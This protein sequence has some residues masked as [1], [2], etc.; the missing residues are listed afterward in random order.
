MNFSRFFVDRP[1][2]ASV[3]S[4][5][6]F[7]VGLISIPS[8]PVSEYPEVVPPSVQVSA[9]YPGANPKTISETVATP[10]EEAING[11]ENMIYMKSV[12]GSDGTLTLN[13]TFKLGTDP[14]Q[15]QVQVQNRVSQAL[16]RLP[17]D[18][19]RQG[20]TTQKQSPNL[21]MAV[22][23]ISP[24]DSLDATYI[25]NYAV[26]HIRDELS[27]IPGVGL[28][29]VF[30]SG[31]YA[32]RL[33]VDPQ[34]AA[35]LGVTAADI[36]SSVREQ[37]VQ[38]SAGQIGASPMPN[39]SDFLISIN[40]KGR[41]QS[42]EEFGNV[43]L[44]TG[45]D[46][47]ITRLR[48][49]AR[50]ELASSQ[51]SLRALLN[52]RQ[53]VAI[54]I[55]QSPGS[56]SLEVSA[57]VREKMAELGEQFP[58]GLEW[59]VAYDPTVFVSTSIS[60]VIKTLLEAVLLVVLVVILFLQ[61]W[62]ASLIPL[63][64][65]PVS[66]VGTFAVLLM[67]GFSINTLTLFAMVLA[68]GIVVDDAIVVVENVE[69]NI[70]EGL[71]PLAAAH[72]AMREVSGPI[73]A[74][75]LVLCAVFV[76]MA[77]LDGIT[78]QFY[79]QFATTIAIATIIS[80]I[81]S[82]TLSP[83]LAATLLKP[84]GA[85]PDIPARIIE[86]LFGWLFRPFNRFFQ[87][88][89]ERY[90]RVVGHSLKRRGIVFGAYL[91]LLGGTFALFQ[92]VPGGFIP[93]QDKTYL[94]GSIR[95]PEGAS[96]DRT[97]E[98]ARRVS[99]LAL[100]TEGVANAA[101]FVGF[102]ALQSTN[103]PNV[104][105]VFILFDDF[106][107]RERSAQEIA[108]ELNGK[109]S[110]IKEG[111]AMTFMP[112]PIFGLGAGSGYSLYVQDRRGA[113][114]GELQNATNMLAGA[115]S[116]ASGLSYPFSSYQANVPQMDAEVDRLQ[117]K[118]Q[119]VRMD[120]LFGTLQLYFGSMYINDFNLFGRTYQVVAQA[121]APFRDEVQDLDNL[122]TRNM[123]GEMVP[124]STMVT[125]RQSYGPDPVIRYNGYPAADLM[126]QSD[127]SMLSS[128]EALAA[129]E[130]V[131]SQALPPGM[132]IQ[133]TDLSFQQVNQ[134]NA[135]MVVFPL[136]VL[137]VFLVLAA[138]YESWVMPLA[139]ILIVPMCL[140]A[141]LFGVWATG[142]D[143]NVFVQV[144]LVVLM[145]L[146]CKNAILIVEF[147]RELEMDGKG[148]VEAALEACRLRLRPIIMTSV[149]FIAGVVPLVLASGA[150][151]EVRN[152][153]GITVFT[154]M[155]GVTLFGL[156]L[157]PVFYVALR[158]IAGGKIST[159]K[160]VSAQQVQDTPLPLEQPANG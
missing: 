149:A 78:G 142:G 21:M 153:M 90:Q 43:V 99:E 53:A 103:T 3:L 152:A 151:A 22:H 64:A 76:P 94:V 73:V 83:A 131:A 160:N 12:A 134:G 98:V 106:D 92:Q 24:D 125:L 40:A 116:Q 72:Q 84:H 2:F 60:S 105:T 68:I 5:I 117:A 150:G 31:D 88:N 55:F 54:P 147:A 38:V 112:P 129:V 11:V 141:A 75:S 132:Q 19:R 128:S 51:D 41:L 101:A 16:P 7:V 138:L 108:A 61:T 130:Q 30:G 44:K 95:L 36:V 107:E 42:E 136:A 120:D 119:G 115:L 45:S 144:G 127:P 71:T 18:V 80:A 137:L 148:P 56:N 139:V 145:G 62:R 82:L 63:L 66:I 140:L 29:A 33:W 158:K 114:Y 133:W 4:I 37:N 156:F 124:I 58:E 96:L 69:R 34:K 50:V 9:R 6:I 111:F 70:E 81:N 118:A 89:S 20:V 27:R 26:L 91:I 46:G 97:E 52:G 39:G 135:A 104:G 14:D 109:I 57:A 17:E 32:M 85:K 13:V 155:I 10:L 123:N 100:E 23:L 122:Y 86:R 110:Q 159:S 87:R 126:G 121:D 65:V 35:A 8:L 48:D 28:A 143:N 154:G 67:L 113:G 1:I 93:V 79:R 74:I 77:F 25:R 59:K 146:A 15:A 47:E 157:T 49:V 102:N